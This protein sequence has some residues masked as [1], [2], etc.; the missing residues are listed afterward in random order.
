VGVQR[1]VVTVRYPISPT[2]EWLNHR[3][4]RAAK[5]V[6]NPSIP[7]DIEVRGSASRFLADL[8]ELH[9]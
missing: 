9:L 5:V 4:E 8:R 1:G 6:L 3:S 7:W 2:D